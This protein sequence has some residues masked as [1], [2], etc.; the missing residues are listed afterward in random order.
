MISNSRAMRTSELLAARESIVELALLAPRVL[1]PLGR[2]LPRGELAHRRV[3]PMRR[4]P[5]LDVLVVTLRERGRFALAG[6]DRDLQTLA[7]RVRVRPERAA[8]DLIASARCPVLVE[9]TFQSRDLGL[10]R[11]ERRGALGELA[12]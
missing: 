1:A 7:E 12:A 9:V 11:G 2:R 4:A 8:D 6:L 5:A 10:L 3:P